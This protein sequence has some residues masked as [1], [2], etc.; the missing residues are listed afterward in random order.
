[1]APLPHREI[2]ITT[3]VLVGGF[4]GAGKTRL[5]L[6]AGQ[7]LRARGMRVGIVTND[8]GGELVDTRLAAAAG[9]DT[10]E[11]TGGC[12]CCRFSDFLRAAER[13]AEADVIL[14]EP[15]GSCTDLS[16]TILQPL[17]RWHGARF[18]LAPFT[19]LVD[20]ARAREL[21]APEAD[22][23]ASFLFRNQL[24][25]ADLVV[26]SKADMYDDLP[27]L[28]G[29]PARRLSA[30]T[31]AGVAAWL[32]EVLDGG[33]AAGSRVLDI[34]YARYAQA[35]ASLGWLNWQ[36][37]VR[38][39]KALTP[40]AVTG[41][42]L[43]ELDRALTA[44]GASIA[45][46]KIFTEAATGYIKASVCRNGEEPGVEGALDAAPA[47][48]HTVVLN[49]RARASPELLL[50]LVDRATGQ[51]RGRLRITHREAFRPAAPKPEHRLGQGRSGTGPTAVVE[52]ETPA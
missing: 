51:I 42:L 20:P 13:L 12:F 43:E 26:F 15:V 22:P 32:D 40:A 25:E 33:M 16:A 21:L 48:A 41:P 11:V 9:F 8:Q 19:V 50:E 2:P 52:G 6:A 46:V 3:I 34:D 14:A 36:G 31:G 47:R 17:K 49:L 28:P 7:V 45:H 10:G 44:A 27:A 4:L 35:E 30:A 24:A 29:I 23:D 5:L 38:L 39:Q 1:M 18:R 37:E